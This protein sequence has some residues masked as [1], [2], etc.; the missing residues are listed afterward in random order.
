MYRLQWR[1][2]AR[3]RPVRLCDTEHLSCQFIKL[4]HPVNFLNFGNVIQMFR[5]EHAPPH[6]QTLCAEPATL[7]EICT[8]EVIRGRLPRRARNLK[9]ELAIEHREELVEDWN[10]RLGVVNWPSGAEVDPGW[11]RER[12]GVNKFWSVPF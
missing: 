5:R 4:P 10:L 12:I 8:L 6:F 3:V 2:G 1:D 11:M 9:V 7:I